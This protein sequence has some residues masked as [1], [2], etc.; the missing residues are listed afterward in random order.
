MIILKFLSVI[1]GIIVFVCMVSCSEKT[2]NRPNIILIMAD[3][4]GYSDIGSYGG[5]IYTPNLDSLAF[6]GTRFTQFYNGA[7]CCPTRASLLTG[8][9]AHQTGLGGMVSQDTG[10]PGY[11][12]EINTQ[13]VTIAEA[14]KTTGYQTMMTGK[15]HVS[16]S[17]TDT[18]AI[19]NWPLQRGFD[20]F[21]GTIIGA[22]SYFTPATLTYGNK[23]IN[24]FSSDFYYTDAISDSATSFIQ[25]HLSRNESPLFLYVAYTAPHWPLHAPEEDIVNYKGAYDK[26]WDQLREERLNRMKALG[27][28]DSK[29]ELSSKSGNRWDSVEDKDWESRRME[30]YAAQISRM[31]RG[32]GR[33]INL[34]K[35]KGEF[36][37]TLILFLADNGGC[38]EGFNEDTQWIRRYGPAVTLMGDSVIYGND[39]PKRPGP[40]NTY[41][42]YG[43]DWASLS[44]TPFRY[45]KSYTHE[46]GIATPFIVHWPNSR[47]LN[48]KIIDKPTHIIDIMPT[49]LDVA[50]TSYPKTLGEHI[51]TPQE[52]VSLLSVLEGD[53]LQDRPL[54]WDH[55]SRA[56]REK[57]WKLVSRA[58]ADWELYNI[59]VDRS[60]MNDLSNEFPEL[61]DSLRSKWESWA[62]RVNVLPRP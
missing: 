8:L 1:S 3:D 34:L 44:N 29:I 52:G 61:V 45:F 14:L 22:G 10:R 19:Y 59:K 21:F 25:N 60:E 40:A 11:L 23:Q 2:D 39:T 13:C 42:S 5:E 49:L 50:Q 30:V 27:I 62:V 6:N 32:I 17:E 26:G 18:T 55:G 54:F 36:E 24:Q 53:D 58:N 46:G 28:I 57:E 31:D 35:E 4:M 16:R 12:G 38:A 9:Y 56:I 33:I 47:I 51:I 43:R 7:R 41:Q 37:N 20:Q 48:N 15:W